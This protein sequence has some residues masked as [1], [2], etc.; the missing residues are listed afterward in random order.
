MCGHSLPVNPNAARIKSA[1]YME[2]TSEFT[3]FI[4]S[5]IQL[6]NNNNNTQCDK[7]SKLGCLKKREMGFYQ[8]EK[9]KIQV[10]QKPKINTNKL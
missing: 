1:S 7:K 8:E 10:E 4:N 5:F 2:P 9:H 3:G 6:K